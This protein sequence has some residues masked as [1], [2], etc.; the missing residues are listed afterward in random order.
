MQGVLFVTTDM[1]VSYP[2]Q[3]VSLP[4][5]EDGRWLKREIS[6]MYGYANQRPLNL[7]QYT[8]KGK[9]PMLHVQFDCG[10]VERHPVCHDLWT[11][12]GSMIL[13]TLYDPQEL[14]YVSRFVY[15]VDPRQGG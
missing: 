6:R 1:Y 11:Q 12:M 10:V 5:M 15:V 14:D 7:N 3:G 8:P 9:T 13:W 2:R 4:R